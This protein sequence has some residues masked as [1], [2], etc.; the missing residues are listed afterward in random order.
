L[1]PNPVP[2]SSLQDGAPWLAKLVQVAIITIVC[3]ILIT[4]FRLGCKPTNIT[5]GPHPVDI[6]GIWN[7]FLWLKLQRVHPDFQKKNVLD[8]GV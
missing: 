6:F 8:I 7:V 3:M 4:T 2:K 1:V 5:G